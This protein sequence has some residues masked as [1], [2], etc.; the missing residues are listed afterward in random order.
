MVIMVGIDK[1][2]IFV[3][4]L[5]LNSL[6]QRWKTELKVTVIELQSATTKTHLL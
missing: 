2:K 5:H 1:C 3:V 4:I 6:S